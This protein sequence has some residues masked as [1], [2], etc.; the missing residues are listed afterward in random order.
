MYGGF[1]DLRVDGDSGLPSENFWPS[2]TD[3]MTVIVMVF[4]T[5]A[6]IFVLR[7]TQLMEQLRQSIKAETESAMRASTA[8][9]QKLSVEEQLERARRQ[10]ALLSQE[11]TA[12]TQADQAKAQQLAQTQQLLAD[13]QQQGAQLSAALSQSQA[14]GSDLQSQLGAAQ[15]E[16]A[17]L[18]DALGGRERELAA[19]AAQV[20]DLQSAAAKQ[21]ADADA[22]RASNESQKADLD[23]LRSSDADSRQ[24]LAA[25]QGDFDT[26]KVKYDKLV[27][28]ART[29]TGRQVAE[30]RYEKVDGSSKIRFRGPGETNFSVVDQDELEQKLAALQKSDPTKLY[31]KVVIPEDS[32]LSYNEAWTFTVDLLNKYDYYYR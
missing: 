25:L 22:L 27:R 30:V 1:R 19:A 7:N 24:H 6:T 23:K 26:L 10:L 13:A 3:V 8:E 4:M 28:P 31:V 14:R 32:G 5:V 29:P 11:L 17:R 12:R 20:K 21:K 9:E 2:F 15:S 18:R 16:S